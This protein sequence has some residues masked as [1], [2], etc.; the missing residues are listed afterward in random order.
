MSVCASLSSHYFRSI[1]RLFSC[2]CSSLSPSLPPHCIPNMFQLF[3]DLKADIIRCSPF[4]NWF[5]FVGIHLCLF[6]FFFVV[7]LSIFWLNKQTGAVSHQAECK[8][9][10]CDDSQRSYCK[11]DEGSALKAARSWQRLIGL[12]TL[13]LETNTSL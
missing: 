2:L 6:P 4:S 1:T 11:V 12:K 9:H 13:L 3:L 8:Q 7:F 5:A 10:L